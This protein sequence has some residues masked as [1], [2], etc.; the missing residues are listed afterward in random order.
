V[1]TAQEKNYIFVV[2]FYLA[3]VGIPLF[4]KLNVSVD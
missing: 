1:A 4:Y 2:S 3:D